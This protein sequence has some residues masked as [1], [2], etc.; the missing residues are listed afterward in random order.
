MLYTLCARIT[1]AEGAHQLARDGAVCA[2]GHARWSRLL[3]P[4]RLERRLSFD[5]AFQG[6]AGTSCSDEHH[7][8]HT[9][10]LRTQ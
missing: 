4:P 6:R 7:R 9:G 3:G 5:V 10:T 2:H 1:T 8:G